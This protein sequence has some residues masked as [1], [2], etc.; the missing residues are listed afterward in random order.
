M[1]KTKFISWYIRKLLGKIKYQWSIYKYSKYNQMV[2]EDNVEI[3]AIERLNVG[4]NTII[5]ANSLLHCGGRKWCNFKGSIKIG[6]DSYI[7]PNSILFGAGEIEIGDN[8]MLGPGVICVSH[9]HGFQESSKVMQ[10]QPMEFGKIIVE[11]DVW[12]GS[13]AV[14]L[15]NIKISRGSIIGAGAVVTRD[16]PSFSIAVGVPAKVIK[17]RGITGVGSG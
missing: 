8:V 6:K 3:R 17:A 2:F 7:G 5:G 1:L 9:Q 14:V 10:D 16:I 12:V 11:D 4:Q 15:P 13:N